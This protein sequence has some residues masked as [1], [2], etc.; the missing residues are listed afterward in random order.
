VI[1]RRIKLLLALVL[2]F[3]APITRAAD[4]IKPSRVITVRDG[5]PQSY[6]SG[7]FQDANGFLWVATLN[8]LGRYDGREFKNYQHTATDTAGLSGNTILFLF[9][10]GDNNIWLCY[11]DDK[12]DQLNTV[13][14]R[15]THIW[16]EKSFELLKHQAGYFK[17]MVRDT[18]GYCW[19]M[20]TDGGVYRIDRKKFSVRH[21]SMAQLGLDKAVIGVGLYANQLMLF[22]MTHVA[23]YD[24]APIRAVYK[25][26]PFVLKKPDNSQQNL[27]SPG[28]R[29]NGDIIMNDSQ[30]I[31]IWNPFTGSLSQIRESRTGGPGKL[32]GGFDKAGNYYFEFNLGINMLRPDNNIMKWAPLTATDKGYPTCIYQD[33][34]GVLWVGTNGFGLR[35]Y[36]LVKTGLPGY[37]NNHSFMGDALIL[38]GVPVMQIEK[39]FLKEAVEFAHRSTTYK[40]SVW[41]TDKFK[42]RADPQLVLCINKQVSTRNFRNRDANTASQLQSVRFLATDAG[43]V[44]WGINQH[45]QFLKFDTKK[46]TYKICG[47]ASFEEDEE[48]NGIIADGDATFYIST[49]RNLARVDAM[50]GKTEKLTSF[51]PTKDLL[52]LSHD[53]DNKNILWIGTLS[54]GLLRFD[55]ETKKMQMFS[56]ATGL[57]N[58]TIYSVIFGNDKL[59]WCSSNKGIFSIDRKSQAIRSFTSRDGLQDDEFNR[60]YYMRLADGSL[61]FGGPLGYAIFNP[62]KLEVDDFNPQLVLTDLNI[63]NRPNMGEFLSTIKTLNLRYD[64]NF[65]TATFAAM[66][67]NLPDKIQYRYRLKGLDKNWI[68]LGNQ[69]KA[70][71]TSL[72]PGSYTLLL[73]ATNTAG[74]WST[75]IPQ[76]KIN[77][78]TP[79]WRTWWFYMALFL[80]IALLVYIVVKFRVKNF[81]KIQAQK[82]QFER[83]AMELHALALRARMNPH[84]IFNCLNSIK[85]LIQEKQDQ[86]AVNYLTTFSVLI[87]N[88]LNNKSNEITLQDE[89]ETC[90]LYLEL[91][92]MRFEERISYRLDIADDEE[93]LQTKVPPLILQ[94]IIENAIVHGL[95]PSEQGGVV[96]IKV[97]R[98]D[99]FGICEV[100]DNGVGRAAAEINKQRSSR[101]HQSKGI[102]L[103]EERITMHNRMNEHGGSLET[104]DLFNQDGTA[105]GTLVI[106]K[107]NMEL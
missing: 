32:I 91:E 70:S 28:I 59:M 98:D 37:A 79:Y 9:D 6:V 62:A 66:Q 102:H 85:A 41:I 104:I 87:R 14:G 89:L 26:Y 57:P 81:H 17:S 2:F 106:I 11:S 3:I 13:T 23:M 22:T 35:Q 21:F 92:A 45:H 61:A 52:S 67:F 12:I 96:S 74:K 43:G 44:L 82:L 90:K 15:I 34:S 47:K 68:M 95:L 46:L 58:N 100:Q 39:T 10:A 99:E 86:K 56:T 48:V 107:F 69:N 75:Y 5:L 78:A 71:Y 77:I 84:F 54:D 93:L 36:N 55:L 65:I 94:P 72:P 19:M 97:Y 31:V 80:L 101:L 18:R 51:L 63:I 8:G 76:I 27:Y 50:T 24:N 20:A 83:E 38:T 40:D 1:L 42:L 7:V 105:S 30:G 33:R 16:K 49:S 103:L 29:P 53:P 25:A 73:N 4:P 64:Q 60:F 88:Q